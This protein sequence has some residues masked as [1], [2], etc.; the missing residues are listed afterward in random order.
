ML[1]MSS[2]TT[3]LILAV[4]I[5]SLIAAMVYNHRRTEKAKSTPTDA[6][7]I[8]IK[9]LIV[10]VKTA[11]GNVERERIVRKEG[12]LFEVKDF[13][14]ELNFVVKRANTATGEIEAKV[15]TLGSESQ[16]SQESIQKVRLHLT[17]L[18]TKQETGSPS[19]N[20]IPHKEETVIGDVPPVK[21]ASPRKGKM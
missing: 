6:V 13:D 3:D 18:P 11:L 12:P 4:L 5:I 7:E 14:L 21:E 1:G 9:D 16:Y 17:T 19:A 2:V 15:V 8:D 20:G 10:G